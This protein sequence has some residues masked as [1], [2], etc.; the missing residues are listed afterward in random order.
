MKRSEK[1]GKCHPSLRPTDLLNLYTP[2]TQKDYETIQQIE[3]GS[4]LFQQLIE[5][6]ERGARRSHFPPITLAITV[7]DPVMV[8]LLIEKGARVDTPFRTWTTRSTTILGHALSHPGVCASPAGQQILT[9]LLE[10][11]ADP[12]ALSVWKANGQWPDLAHHPL[13]IALAHALQGDEHELS[14][15]HHPDRFA[16]VDLMLKKG[17]NIGQCYETTPGIIDIL[18]GPLRLSA[19]H[20]HLPFP[21]HFM[22]KYTL[23]LLLLYRYLF[24]NNKPIP[25]QTDGILEALIIHGQNAFVTWMI[26]KGALPTRLLLGAAVCHRRNELARLIVEKG[27]SPF[28]KQFVYMESDL[29]ALT[30]G[31]TPSL[32][33]E[34][35]ALIQA[36]EHNNDEI[37][38][39]FLSLPQAATAINVPYKESNEE[40]TVLNS[41]LETNSA[42]CVTLLLKAGA[43]PCDSRTKIRIPKQRKSVQRTEGHLPNSLYITTPLISALRGGNPV[44]LEQILAAI[45]AS[46]ASQQTKDVIV[47]AGILYLFAMTDRMP[48]SQLL[49]YL[50]QSHPV[51]FHQHPVYYHPLSLLLT[52][53]RNGGLCIPQLLAQGVSPATLSS[54]VPLS[55]NAYVEYFRHYRLEVSPLEKPRPTE[56]N[57]SLFFHWLVSNLVSVALIE[58][59]TVPLFTLCP[60]A[61][62]V[63]KG[64]HCADLL[65]YGADPTTLVMH[66]DTLETPISLACLENNREAELALLISKLRD[67]FS[68][69]EIRGSSPLGWCIRLDRIKCM[70][71]L[72]ANKDLF[73]DDL[74]F[75][76]PEFTMFIAVLRQ[77]KA[78]IKLLIDDGF[79]LNFLTPLEM[80]PSRQPC[81]SH[82]QMSNDKAT[83][84]LFVQ[85]GADIFLSA[86]VSPHQSGF[87]DACLN[88]RSSPFYLRTIL[89]YHFFRDL[90]NDHPALHYLRSQDDFSPLIAATLAGN[91]EL[92]ALLLTHGFDPN[93]VMT[94]GLYKEK[95]PVAVALA[96]NQRQIVEKMAAVGV[97]FDA[98]VPSTCL[99]KQSITSLVAS[100]LGFRL[101]DFMQPSLARNLLSEAR[102]Y[103]KDL[104]RFGRIDDSELKES[105]LHFTLF[106]FFEALNQLKRQNASVEL[107][108]SGEMISGIRNTLRHGYAT[109]SLV[110]YEQLATFVLSHFSEKIKT[111]PTATPDILGFSKEQTQKMRLWLTQKIRKDNKLRPMQRQCINI[112]IVRQELESLER[113]IVL[114][115][116]MPRVLADNHAFIACHRSLFIIGECYQQCAKSGVDWSM[117]GDLMKDALMISNAAAHE[118]ADPLQNG[119]DFNA[120][121]ILQ[122]AR[123][124]VEHKALILTELEAPQ[125]TRRTQPA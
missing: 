124:L 58:S 76:N 119:T 57:Q 64:A 104:K 18:A 94:S 122:A 62:A 42:A 27:V 82:L 72:L 61:F 2:I 120:V 121:Y 25:E 67:Q 43:D 105:L 89:K 44:L 68:G 98:V 3:A 97:N 63:L 20:H 51:I 16:I 116:R 23:Y 117:I 92:V 125:K 34:S 88:F 24:E 48:P 7:N 83:F 19:L 17:A 114:L 90:E 108:L 123:H 86:P 1:K 71:I 109:L 101:N 38:T 74:L 4:P 115:E 26:K 37:L 69:R 85:S 110:D 95:S 28:E 73:Q 47:G 12:N 118:F 46:S 60:L 113:Y 111:S 45:E 78:I 33:T 6:S 22:K 29:L 11:G 106:R 14:W 102:S 79:P 55:V 75:K 30:S 8:A 52:W 50:H 56:G 31:A 53:R 49:P 54:P 5:V 32:C 107:A 103:A 41:A 70:P 100:T 93:E 77:N 9:I 96:Q 59:N 80:K 39:Y 66:I 112:G 36:C 87:S 84:K 91:E 81:L 21:D 40:S 99:K 65:A 15:L 13:G 35:S 10:A